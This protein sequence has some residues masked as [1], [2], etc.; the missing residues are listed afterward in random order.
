[1][2]DKKTP[3][4]KC[5]RCDYEYLPEEVLYPDSILGKPFGIVR[6]KEGKIEFFAGNTINLNESF[7]CF[8]CG[9]EFE[10]EGTVKFNTAEKD[11]GIFGEDYVTEVY[12]QER[13]DLPEK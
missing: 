5:P 11:Y 3:I 8:N 4:I 1:M 2:I 9:C 12:E 6:D 10:V 7:T 13:V